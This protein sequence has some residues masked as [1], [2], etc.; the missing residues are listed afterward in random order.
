ME[1]KTADICKLSELQEEIRETLG[2]HFRKPRWIVGEISEIKENF[3]GHCYLDLVEKDEKSDKFLAKAR[4][5]IWSSTWRM[6]K[7]YFETS[8]GYSLVAGI[9]IMVSASVEYHPVYGLSLNIRDIDPSYTLGDVERRR[10]EI[11]RKLEEEG[12]LDMNKETGLPVAPQ[13]IAIISSET[14]AGYEDFMEQL[15]NNPYGY[16]FYTLLYP[17]IM[18]G[19][20]TE[21]TIIE[22]LEKIFE[23]EEFFDLVVIIRGGGSKAELAS[24]DNYE[25]AFHVSQFPIPVITGIGHEQDDTIVDLVAHTR[26]KTPTAVAG[27]LIDRLAA[28]ESLLDEYAEILIKNC[29]EI[30]HENELQLQIQRQRTLSAYRDFARS[31]G[32]RLLR[33]ISGARHL[34][35]N[36][37]S[38]HSIHLLRLTE[39]LKN[40]GRYIPEKRS[41]ELEYVRARITGSVPAIFEQEHKKLENYMKLKS[42]AEPSQILKLGFSISRYNNKALKD[43]SLI[44][45]GEEMETAL[46]S[47]K[48][49]SRVTDIEKKGYIRKR[50]NDS[51]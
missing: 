46:Y 10:Q 3:S 19:D 15:L 36:T 28:F 44:R 24:F 47:G 2:D 42:Y 23:Q 9:K 5:T 26:L 41:M 50:K 17:A 49:K 45:E 12:V 20:Q 32:E 4:A 31:S 22:A 40:L 39:N 35:Q 48:I 16:K 34:I 1:K 14:A 51:G 33:T 18:Q 11:I 8:T 38:G 30:L 29:Q 6:L 21:S 37:I 43:S 27:F 25:L 13:K 7:P